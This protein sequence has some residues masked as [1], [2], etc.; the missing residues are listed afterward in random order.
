MNKIKGLERKLVNKDAENDDLR[1]Q[2]RDTEFK[3]NEMK[4]RAMV[5][6]QRLAMGSG[7]QMP[8]MQPNLGQFMPFQ[9]VMPRSVSNETVICP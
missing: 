8:Y 3:Y 9:Q 2:V 5:Y 6:K 4:K 7:M 1:K